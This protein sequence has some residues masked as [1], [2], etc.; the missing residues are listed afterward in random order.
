M[1]VDSCNLI[2]G[3][4]EIYKNYDSFL[5]DLWGVVHNGVKVFSS[6][7]K[8]LEELKN[9]KK[10]VILLT[11][12]PRRSSV[13]KKQLEN[14][15]I[16][17]D[18]YKAVVSSGE[19]S[20]ISIK[21][22]VLSSK[23]KLK[24]FHIG[25]PR[26]YHLTYDL[27]IEIVKDFKKADFILNTGPWGEKDCLDN[28]KKTLID[29]ARLNLP[30][31]CSNP[32]KSVI[33]GNNFMICAGLLAEFYEN[34]GGLVEYFGKPYSS[35]Y[36]SCYEI[37]GS[38]DPKSILVVGDSLENDIKGANNQKIDS[39]LVANGIHREIYNNNHIDIDK[40]NDLIIEKKSVPNF[41]ISEFIW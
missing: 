40:L 14:F 34:L 13:I 32:D 5:I 31:I 7:K 19:A 35:I 22:K 26:D 37:I 27:N 18:L 36:K 28:Y 33:R 17:N 39:L 6:S 1:K 9:K 20:W 15:G 29:L 3:L 16:P 25:P 11:N 23:N 38:F 30:M 21:K 8:A 24:C 10:E 2:L 41:V 4:S 12:A